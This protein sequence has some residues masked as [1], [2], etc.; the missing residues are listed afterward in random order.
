MIR[1]RKDISAVWIKRKRGKEAMLSEK[2]DQ[3]NAILKKRS[4][5]KNKIPFTRG[6]LVPTTRISY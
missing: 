5:I 6:Y 3:R 1:V 4:E 2:H